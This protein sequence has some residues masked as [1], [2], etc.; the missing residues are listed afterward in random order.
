VQTT[1]LI[2]PQVDVLEAIVLGTVQGITEFLPISSRAHLILI[3][4]L[5]GWPDP[6]LT[7]DVAL[8]LGTLLALLL[9]YWKDWVY[10]TRSAFRLLKGD[11]EDPDSRLAFYLILATIPGGIAGLL[12]EQL[13][14]QLSTPAVIAATLIGVALLMRIAEVRGRRT[15]DLDTMTL[16]DALTVG[17]AQALAI[18]PGVSRSGVTITAGLFRNLNRFAAAEF[19]FLLSAPIVGGAVAKKVVD[20]ARDGLPPD[21]QVSF[22]VGTIVSAFVGLIFMAGLIRYL[23]NHT[24]F[25]FINYRIVLGIVVLVLGYFWNLQ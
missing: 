11:I 25:V 13:E 24:T 15:S 22:A 5:F 3:P 6:G 4:W 18:I 12:F 14:D 1:S 9:Y 10:L 20:I 7:F 16:P 2:Q 21:Q 23:K 17:F 19:S 8:H